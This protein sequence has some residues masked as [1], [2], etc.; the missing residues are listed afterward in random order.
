MSTKKTGK[1]TKSAAPDKSKV[2]TAKTAKQRKEEWKARQERGEAVF[3]L[4][5][6]V[7]EARDAFLT[8]G[9][10]PEW[11]SED[12]KEIGEIASRIVKAVI[13]FVSGHGKLPLDLDTVGIRTLVGL[14]SDLFA[15]CHRERS[16][17][18]FQVTDLRSATF[19]P[20]PTG[21]LIVNAL[22]SHLNRQDLDA[23]LRL[24]RALTKAENNVGSA[25]I[26]DPEFLQ[27]VADVIKAT[28][29]KETKSLA[30][31]VR[32]LELATGPQNDAKRGVAKARA[33]KVKL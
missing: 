21:G 24:A 9:V 2:S 31:R 33:T 22:T 17:N 19:K 3:P 26:D 28:V 16:R 29:E 11:D 23:V 27:D 25:H 12:P 30:N 5:L 10:L 8:A 32:L 13:R 6:K 20:R 15:N 1:N 7:G 4:T 14:P 18:A